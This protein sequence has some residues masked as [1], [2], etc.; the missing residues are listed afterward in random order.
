MNLDSF[1]DIFANFTLVEMTVYDFF[2]FKPIRIEL[3]IKNFLKL[4]N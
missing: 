4:Q 1:F 3:R 2:K